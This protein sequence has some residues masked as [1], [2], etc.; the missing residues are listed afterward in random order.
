MGRRRIV[1]TSVA[2]LGLL[3]TVGLAS[4]A[5]TSG[6]GG[7]TRALDN[8][9]L[10]EYTLLLVAAAAVVI[11]PVTVYAFVVGNKE[12]QVELPARRNWMLALLLTMSGFAVVSIVLL[13]TGFFKHHHGGASTAPLKPL[14]ALVHRGANAPRVVRFDWVPVIVVSVLAAA[15]LGGGLLMV[16]RSRP[17]RTKRVVDALVGAIDESLIDL[18]GD[19]DPRSA[20]IAAY[21][22]MEHVLGW[23]GLPRTPSEAP[24]EYLHRVLPGIGAGAE[25]V[26]RLTALYE[27]ARFSS[28]EIDGEMRDEAI[29]AF[30]ALRDELQGA[31]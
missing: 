10:L 14:I 11:I 31:D 22:H 19:L 2:L 3:A 27:R 7:R 13:A 5:H 25:S 30:E 26:E 9:I 24:R 16:K 21:A 28:H 4:R 20:V 8:D 12:E 6:G 29:A 15:G 23:F 18:H 17:E 1:L